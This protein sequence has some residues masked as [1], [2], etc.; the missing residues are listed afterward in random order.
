V[1]LKNYID[2]KPE[3]KEK[4]KEVLDWGDYQLL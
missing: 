2:L 3:E 1:L 4:L